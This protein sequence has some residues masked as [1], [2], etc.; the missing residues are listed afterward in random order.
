MAEAITTATPKTKAKPSTGFETPKFEMPKF[1]MPKLEMPAALREFAEKGVAQAKDNYE[2]MKAVAEETTDLL[3][4]T[5]S[6][7]T[8][9]CSE[10]GL[11]LI[12]VSRENSNAAF[13]FFSELLGTKS[14]LEIVELSTKFAREQFEK[15]M[16]QSKD[17]AALAQKVCTDTAEPIK[18]GV[19]SAFNK[20]A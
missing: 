11:K 14:A 8:K 3:E 19:T 1:E 12:E 7:A 6:T 17:L 15:S 2:K 16:A 10:Y 9:G 5:Y 20:A 18:N 4:D 13:D